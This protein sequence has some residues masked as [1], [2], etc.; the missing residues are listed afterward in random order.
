ML[1]KII[2]FN[3]LIF[4]YKICALTI[5]NL[6]KLTL[7]FDFICMSFC[8]SPE[9]HFKAGGAPPRKTIPPSR[10]LS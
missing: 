4:L 9:I 3:I 10:K 1:R 7:N 8:T 5:K 2:Y 6:E